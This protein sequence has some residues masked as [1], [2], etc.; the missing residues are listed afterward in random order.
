MKKEYQSATRSKS[1]IKDAY[2]TLMQEKKDEKIFVKEITDKANINRCTFYSHYKDVNQLLGDIHSQLID[3][4]LPIF[5]DI[6]AK[7]V[8][9]YFNL[10]FMHLSD[11]FENN[12]SYIQA[13]LAQNKSM[14]YLENIRIRLKE[15]IMQTPF[16][17]QQLSHLE[18]ACIIIDYHISAI[19]YTY[20]NWFKNLIPCDIYTLSHTLSTILTQ[21]FEWISLSKDQKKNNISKKVQN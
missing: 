3:E 14:D 1:A 4:I 12:K 11:T 21:Q 19:I 5:D 20:S 13:I 8:G 9:E 2:L 7:T 17:Y 16:L 6:S 18:N 10:F 15:K